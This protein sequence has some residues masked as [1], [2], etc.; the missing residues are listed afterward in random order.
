MPPEV[1]TLSAVGTSRPCGLDHKINPFNCSLS[2]A[3]G[4]TATAKVQYTLSDTKDA[5]DAIGTG[6]TWFDHATLNGGSVNAVGNFAF[7]VS[8]V[9]LVVSAWTSGNVILTVLQAG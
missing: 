4:G 3:F 6:M 8:A 2:L 5:T 9:R 1:R 7:P